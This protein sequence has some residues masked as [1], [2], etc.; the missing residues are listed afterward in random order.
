V[1]HLFAPFATTKTNGRGLGL[2]IAARMAEEHG[3][4]LVYDAPEHGGARFTLY[5]PIASSSANPA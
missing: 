5:L 2:A 4:Q 3:G 1:P